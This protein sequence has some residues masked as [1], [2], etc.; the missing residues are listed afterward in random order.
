MKLLKK[1]GS[2]DQIVSHK[3][4]KIVPIYLTTEK[5]QAKDKQ[6]TMQ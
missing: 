1:N 5:K 3:K 2:K 4:N 6:I